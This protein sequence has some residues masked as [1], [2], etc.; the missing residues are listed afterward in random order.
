MIEQNIQRSNVLYD[1][2]KRPTP[3][4]PRTNKNPD[5]QERM[6][7]ETKDRDKELRLLQIGHKT[8]FVQSVIRHISGHVE[9][10]SNYVFITE[11]LAI[12]SETIRYH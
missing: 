11:R 4:S 8:S 5:S 2:R 1:Q 9:L 6:D 12:T 10:M 7:M 3:Q